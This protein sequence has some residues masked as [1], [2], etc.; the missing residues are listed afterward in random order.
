MKKGKNLV[1]LAL[2]VSLIAGITIGAGFAA[3]GISTEVIK[4]SDLFYGY[5]YYLKADTSEEQKDAAWNADYKLANAR[6]L[7]DKI[8][9]EAAKEQNEEIMK[10]ITIFQNSTLNAMSSNYYLFVFRRIFY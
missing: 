8:I 3:T 10:A 1:I 6:R 5:P 2:C 7:A 4:T 9:G